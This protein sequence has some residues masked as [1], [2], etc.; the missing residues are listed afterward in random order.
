MDERQTRMQVATSQR[1]SANM[2]HSRFFLPQNRDGTTLECS[3]HRIDVCG[4]FQC[5][6]LCT[7]LKK[8]GIA[9]RWR[10]TLHMQGCAHCGELYVWS[11]DDRLLHCV[12]ASDYETRDKHAGNTPG[13]ARATV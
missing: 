10:R 9:A 11:R 1:T 4:I 8:S 12:L 6:P 3:S 13:A 5:A 7:D 2:T